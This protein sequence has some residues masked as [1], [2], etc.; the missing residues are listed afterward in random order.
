MVLKDTI[1]KG[2]DKGK[3]KEKNILP[4]AFSS[5]CLS[6]CYKQCTLVINDYHIV[7]SHIILKVSTFSR[8]STKQ[9]WAQHPE[10]KPY[11]VDYEIIAL[12]D[13][14]HSDPE[15]DINKLIND[16]ETEFVLKESLE[17]ELNSDD[18]Q[19][20]LLVPEANY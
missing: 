10:Y 11:F 1:R 8:L 14:V 3:S 5:F 18:E 20:N 7:Y 16:S 12:L 4:S 13:E 15:D 2:K 9:F 19:L 6:Q 17:N